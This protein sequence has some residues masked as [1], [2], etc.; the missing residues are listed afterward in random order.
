MRRIQP[1]LRDSWGQAVPTPVGAGAACFRATR[2]NYFHTSRF[3]RCAAS[4]AR[5]SQRDVPTD[6]FS[7]PCG[8]RDVGNAY[9]ALKRRA[10]IAMSL[11]NKRARRENG[12]SEHR[13]SNIERRTPKGWRDGSL[14]RRERSKTE[15]T[16]GT[17]QCEIRGIRERKP[18]FSHG[19]HYSVCAF[20]R[21]CDFAL[22]LVSRFHPRSTLVA[23][24]PCR[25]LAFET[26]PRLQ[27][28]TMRSS[29][30][31]DRGNFP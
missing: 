15:G 26:K 23:A 1:F 12:K 20:S 21:P 31:G 24:P 27:P 3:P 19:G 9:P 28:P 10:I 25:G 5:T 18:H 14:N 8:T 17:E 11:R 22:K 6:Q 30:H 16:S 4:A 13:T 29:P 7:R 2:R